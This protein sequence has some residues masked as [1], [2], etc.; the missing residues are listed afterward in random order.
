MQQ[1]AGFGCLGASICWCAFE[2]IGNVAFALALRP[3]RWEKLKFSLIRSL[4]GSSI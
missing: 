3:K 2:V 1:E 4:D